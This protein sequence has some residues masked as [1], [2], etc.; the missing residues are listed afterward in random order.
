MNVILENDSDQVVVETNNFDNTEAVAPDGTRF[1][2]KEKPT[3]L[4]GERWDDEHG[5]SYWRK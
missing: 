5:V 3:N 2:L 4:S 1:E